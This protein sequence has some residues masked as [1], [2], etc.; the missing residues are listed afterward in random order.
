[1]VVESAPAHADESTLVVPVSE[2]AAT[3]PDL[4]P[5][6]RW[7][8]ASIVIWLLFAGG[9]IIFV[10]FARV[11]IAAGWRQGRSMRVVDIWSLFTL[12]LAQVAGP[13]VTPALVTGLVLL[14]FAASMI[15]L[16]LAMAVTSDKTSE[17]SD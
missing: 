17:R 3:E 6:R 15:C 14:V 5:T 10:A 13:L 12:E 1:M 8:P 7:S 2:D 4:A 11:P 16:W 9:I